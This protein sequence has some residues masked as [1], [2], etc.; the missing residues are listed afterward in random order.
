M[1]SAPSKP[2]MEQANDA[3]GADYERRRQAALV[4]VDLKALDEMFADDLVHIHSV[5]L[6]HDKAE[7]L[8]HIDAKRGFAA[9][10]RGH[11]TVRV[12]SEDAAVM[13][14]TITTHIPESIPP[15]RHQPPPPQPTR[16]W[17]LETAAVTFTPN[18]TYT[19]A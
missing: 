2:A 19:A 1:L 4:N 7:L 11:L 9:I 17:E 10:E 6:V 3:A 15:P 13:T 16:G 12:L 14:G 5:G 18:P 8:A